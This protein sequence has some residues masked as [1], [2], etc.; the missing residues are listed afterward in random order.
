MTSFDYLENPRVCHRRG[1]WR[2]Q[3][4]KVSDGA[5]L[6]RHVLIDAPIVG[7]TLAPF[8]N[9]SAAHLAV[10]TAIWVDLLHG[11]EDSSRKWRVNHPQL[12]INRVSV[13]CFRKMARTDELL[14]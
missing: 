13:S 8:P 5:V 14:A 3:R 11:S 7:A 9:R 2:P 1:G 12:P 4:L 6:G 10:T